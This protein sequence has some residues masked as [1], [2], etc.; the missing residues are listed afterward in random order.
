MKKRFS[1]VALA[2]I[3]ISLFPSQPANAQY[4]Q[5][6]VENDVFVDLTISSLMKIG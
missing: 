2:A 5:T 6:G 1:L 4:P 3:G